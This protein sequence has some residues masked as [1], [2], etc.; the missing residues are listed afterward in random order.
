MYLHIGSISVGKQSMYGPLDIP[1]EVF[2]VVL[3]SQ[4]QI[5]SFVIFM[6]Q[7]RFS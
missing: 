4:C 5:L 7:D 3:F 6:Y 1:L 2:L